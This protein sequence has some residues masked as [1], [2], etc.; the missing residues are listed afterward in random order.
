M[1]IIRGKYQRKVIQ[2][3]TNLPVRPTTDMA[4]ES[5]FNIL[6]N[7]IDFEELHVLDLF[8]GTG[9]ISYE[10]VS[11][12][13]KVTAV[14]NNFHCIQFIHQTAEKLSMEHLKTVKSDVFQFLPNH[15]Q[16]YN[17]IFADPPF[18]SPDYQKLVDLIFDQQ[19]LHTDGILVVEHPISISFTEH[20]KF[21]DQRH[22]GKV[23][24]SFFSNEK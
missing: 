2:A 15:H 16:K 5:L 21:T 14:D 13:S 6:N 7:L 20:P 11:R 17:L 4:K 23:N 9:N 19:L 3:P 10:F 22:Y 12:G 1:R 24:F 8:A 18:D